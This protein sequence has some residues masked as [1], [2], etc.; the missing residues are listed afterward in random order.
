MD[1]KFTTHKAA[2]CLQKKNPCKKIFSKVIFAT[3]KY[4]ETFD[5]KYIK[6]IE[7]N[8]K[9]SEGVISYFHSLPKK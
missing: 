6:D 2:G 3:N 7:K 1:E 8:I 4:N 5:N 9:E